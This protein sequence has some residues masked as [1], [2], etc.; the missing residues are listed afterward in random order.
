MDDKKIKENIENI[1]RLLEKELADEQHLEHHKRLSKYKIQYLEENT[2]KL[3]EAVEGF[4]KNNDDDSYKRF[5]IILSSILEQDV[6]DSLSFDFLGKEEVNYEIIKI[7]NK[8]HDILKEISYD[9]LSEVKKLIE[10]EFYIVQKEIDIMHSESSVIKKLS[11]DESKNEREKFA[12]S[13]VHNN[14]FMFFKE[15]RLSMGKEYHK[16]MN[17]GAKKFNLSDQK[18]KLDALI[19]SI[20]DEE[21]KEVKEILEEI[22]KKL[23]N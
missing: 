6:I 17:E 13:H 9:G 10:L 7:F 18:D 2:S 20:K 1:N 22:K 21:L 8:L 4:E 14:I 5:L 15:L 11:K 3:L 23:F 12:L 16:L 19:G